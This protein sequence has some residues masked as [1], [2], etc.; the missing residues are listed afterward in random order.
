MISTLAGT[1]SAI[2]DDSVIV[3]VGGVGWHVYNPKPRD[4]ALNSPVQLF[5]AW[6]W[7][8]ENGPALFGFSTVT[9]REFFNVV[10]SCSGFGPKI[11]LAV[12]AALSPAAFCTAVLHDDS[13]TLS[14]VP[15]IGRKKAETLIFHLKP[16]ISDFMLAHQVTQGAGHHMR[17][18]S[19]ALASLGYS[20]NEITLALEQIGQ[21][22]GRPFDEIL[23]GAL[24]VLSRQ[25]R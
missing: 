15:G 14:S 6:T 4:F 5:I 13:A 16:K 10:T 7:S 8:A 22:S 24:A 11:G 18:L 2:F 20:R 23:R 21:M 12:V 3:T 19:E 9:E 25:K 17:E 1:V